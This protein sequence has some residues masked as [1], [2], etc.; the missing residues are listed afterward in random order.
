MIT[1]LFTYRRR[2][3]TKAGEDVF[4]DN[5]IN[6]LAVTSMFW[7]QNEHGQKI[8]NVFLYNGKTVTFI[9]SVGRRMVQHQE[10][11]LRF[12]LGSQIPKTAPV[13]SF[14]HRTPVQV[15]VVDEDLTQDATAEW[16][17]P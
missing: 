15:E 3:T 16:V 14:R 7:E 10:D 1:A 17:Q 9:E 6:P 13:T 11:F 12:L 2:I 4:N 8:L 5:F